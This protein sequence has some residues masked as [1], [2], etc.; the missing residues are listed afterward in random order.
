M[1]VGTGIEMKLSDYEYFFAE[2]VG[3]CLRMQTLP[4]VSRVLGSRCEAVK[5]AIEVRR[6]WTILAHGGCLHSRRGRQRRH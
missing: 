5:S 2:L 1:L 4:G 6:Y 3:N